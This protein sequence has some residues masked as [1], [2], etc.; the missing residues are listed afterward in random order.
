[1]R[2][3]VLRLG[4]QTATRMRTI[5]PYGKSDREMGGETGHWDK[6]RCASQQQTRSAIDMC[7]QRLLEKLT[8]IVS[9][10]QSPMVEPV[11]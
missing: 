7:S 3:A 8:M 5:G 9:R 6:Q 1:M 10:G 2:L 4:M 11:V